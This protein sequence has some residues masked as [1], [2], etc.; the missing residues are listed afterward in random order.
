MPT[1]SVNSP[2]GHLDQIG[3]D[4]TDQTGPDEANHACPDCWPHVV[5]SENNDGL[6]ANA[7]VCSPNYDVVAVVCPSA[8]ASLS[9]PNR[10]CGVGPSGP[11]RMITAPNS[12]NNSSY[13]AVNFSGKMCRLRKALYGLK[14]SPRVWFRRFT[15]EI[16]KYGYRQGNADYTLFIKCRDGKVTLLIIY[17]DDMIVTCDDTMEIEHLQGHLSSEFEMKDLRGLKYFLGIEVARKPDIAYAVSVVSQFM[18]APSEDHM[19]AVMRI[20]SYLKGALGKGLMYRK[21]GHMEVKWYTDVDWVGNIIDR[22]STSGY[23]AFVAGFKPKGYMLLYCDNQ[24][25]RE[26]ANNPVQHDMTN[27]VEVDRHFIKEKLDVKLVDIPFVKIEEQLAD[28]LTH[29]VSARRFQDSL[30]KLGLGD[31]HAPT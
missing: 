28:I 13:G 26:I 24:V 23:F 17:V 12:S 6:H 11:S 4:T 22:R 14:Q 7:A 3:Q 10:N 30:D 15:Q 31:I 2:N 25:A 19:A 29:A 1:V 16:K 5:P 18:H 8:A 21:H 27:H 20:L 9:G